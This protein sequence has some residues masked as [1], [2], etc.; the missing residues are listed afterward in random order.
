MKEAELSF[1]VLFYPL[2]PST[3]C[4][5]VNFIK[6]SSGFA[7]CENLNKDHGKY[8][9]NSR[10]M[11]ILL[12]VGCHAV[13]VVAPCTCCKQSGVFLG[14]NREAPGLS[15]RLTEAL[16]GGGLCFK[17]SKYYV[18]RAS[19]LCEHSPSATLP[20]FCFCFFFLISLC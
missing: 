8:P 3:V 12:G 10:N 7:T 6:T 16:T 2:S 18:V 14:A 1:H 11:G 5:C 13:V 17:M 20:P 15:W 19:F 4:V 9:Y